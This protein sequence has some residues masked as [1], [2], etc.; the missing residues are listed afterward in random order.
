MILF[1]PACGGDG[2]TAPLGPQ[3]ADV[4]G[5]W[6]YDANMTGTLS[7][8]ALTCS[9]A[10]RTMTLIQTGATFS[11]T[12]SSGTLTCSAGGATIS[13]PFGTGIVNNGQVDGNSVQFDFGVPDWRHTGTVNGGS[14]SGS[15]TLVAELTDEVV[16]VTGPWAAARQ[17][18]ASVMPLG[19]IDDQRGTSPS[20]LLKEL[21]R[22]Q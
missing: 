17:A 21:K 15:V 3:H 18:S 8:F 12:V 22:L 10:G 9:L 16:I 19:K 7:G 20:A 14:M 6:S 13:D 2:T 5:V 1:L 4:E 11:G